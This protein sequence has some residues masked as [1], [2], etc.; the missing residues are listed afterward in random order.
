MS[1]SHYVRPYRRRDGTLVHGHTR[2]NP[3]PRIGPTGV[4]FF[5]IVLVIVG[6]LVLG[7]G[8]EGGTSVRHSVETTQQ[9]VNSP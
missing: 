4:F 2:R 3:S 7:H 9:H 8:H 6:G 1:G 5:V